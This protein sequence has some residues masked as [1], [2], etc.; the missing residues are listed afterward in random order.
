[1]NF[2]VEFELVKSHIIEEYTINITVTFNVAHN[3]IKQHGNN[4]KY[5]GGMIINELLQTNTYN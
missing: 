2:S 5:F 1:M 4:G 3:G